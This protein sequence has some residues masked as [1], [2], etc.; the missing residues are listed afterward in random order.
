MACVGSVTTP[1]ST[2]VVLDWANTL[3]ALRTKTN[4]LVIS[5]L[6]P[7]LPNNITPLLSNPA[8][9]APPRTLIG[10]Y[11]HC[12]LLCRIVQ[13]C[14]AWVHFAIS[15]G[16]HRYRRCFDRIHHHCALLCSLFP[17]HVCVET[18][19]CKYHLLSNLIIGPRARG[20]TRR[21]IGCL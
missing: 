13:F 20:T 1:V 9:A 11:Q 5:R 12:A 3:A 14:N 4:N 19:R 15:F 6:P 18:F 10:D 8:F 21:R 17:C 2:A 7:W 16:A